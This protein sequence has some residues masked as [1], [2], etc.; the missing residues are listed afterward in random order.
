MEMLTKVLAT[1]LFLTV[2]D[3]A[4]AIV[5][6]VYT[7]LAVACMIAVFIVLSDLQE[8]GSWD[9][10]LDVVMKHVGGASSVVLRDARLTLMLPF[11]VAFGF[12]SSFVPYYVFG[13]VIADSATLGATYVGL[14]SAVIVMTGASMAMPAAWAANA[15]G[16]PLVMVVGGS[17]LAFSGFIF[18]FLTDA[19]LGTWGLII[20]YLVVY[21]IGRGTWVSNAH[22]CGHALATV[23]FVAVIAALTIVAAVATVAAVAAL[24]IVASVAYENVQIVLVGN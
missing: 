20:F 24:T 1:V 18:F 2:P 7:V 22:Q 9:F 17:C 14:L 10:Q 6:T 21:G 16:K 11:Q 13:T 4:T 8:Q 5:F 12:A 19:Q 3:S 15:F 23:A